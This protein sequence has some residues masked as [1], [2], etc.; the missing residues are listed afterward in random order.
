MTTEVKKDLW[1]SRAN[2]LVDKRNKVLNDDI[3]NYKQFSRNINTLVESEGYYDD[4]KETT[5][6]SSML[7]SR[8]QAAIRTQRQVAR[9][10]EVPRVYGW[11]VEEVFLDYSTGDVVEFYASTDDLSSASGGR[12]LI[13]CQILQIKPSYSEIGRKYKVVAMTYI[14]SLSGAISIDGG[15]D[16]NLWVAAGAPNTAQDLVFIVSGLNSGTTASTPAIRAGTMPEGSTVTLVLIGGAK[17][18]GTGGS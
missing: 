1:N 10:S 3:Q 13:R 6:D 18:I 9:F 8:V 2:I 11:D 15:V 17:N 16:T 7:L 12:V 5:L 14:P 4:S